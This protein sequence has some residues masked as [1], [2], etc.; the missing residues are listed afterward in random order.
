MRLIDAENAK[1][2]IR[3]TVEHLAEAGNGAMAGSLLFAVE[4]IDNAPTVD[5]VKHGKWIMDFLSG[6]RRKHYKC[7][8]CGK[9]SANASF[10]CPYCGAKMDE[11]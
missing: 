3:N 4:V 2:I 10:Y 1:A 5:P 8:V 7:S 6:Y 11:E 9:R